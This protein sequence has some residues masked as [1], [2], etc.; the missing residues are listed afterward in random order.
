MSD[1]APLNLILLVIAGVALAWGFWLVRRSRRRL[2]DTPHCRACDYDLTANAS[3]VCPECGLALGDANVIRGD[4]VRLRGRFAR[5][6]LLIALALV[7]GGAVAVSSAQ[8]YDWYRLR[9]T[10]WVIDDAAS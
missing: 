8:N 1:V 10:S 3:D 6:L 4:P 2:G 5:G 7:L 9:P